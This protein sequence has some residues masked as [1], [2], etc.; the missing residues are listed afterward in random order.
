MDFMDYIIKQLGLFLTIAALL[1]TSLAK[2]TPSCAELTA[3]FKEAREKKEYANMNYAA[4]LGLES[5]CSD[6][7]VII[8][9]NFYRHKELKKA[10]DFFAAAAEHGSCTAFNNLRALHEL[11]VINEEIAIPTACQSDTSLSPA[12][13]L[14]LKRL[15]YDKS[16]IAKIEA[17]QEED[18]KNIKKAE[19]YAKSILPTVLVGTCLMLTGI[20]LG[21]IG[22]SFYNNS[23]PTTISGW[24][25][26]GAGAVPLT[27]SLAAWG[28]K[29]KYYRKGGYSISESR[30]GSD[31]IRV[32]YTDNR[33]YRYQ[34]MQ[35]EALQERDTLYPDP[36]DTSTLDRE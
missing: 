15:A 12:I 29:R 24:V 31:T 18:L 21:A 25:L 11:E 35:E 19:R 6:L 5:G 14:T 7:M 8:G 17:Q 23:H 20:T 34:H 33:G 36:F 13:D 4:R 10:V 26:T 9:E 28:L 3:A 2:A 27:Y 22:V 30:I 1:V 32:T 16:A